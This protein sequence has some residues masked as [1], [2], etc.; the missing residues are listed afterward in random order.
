MHKGF[1]EMESEEGKGTKVI[2]TLKI[3]GGGGNE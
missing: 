3:T 2:I 1:I